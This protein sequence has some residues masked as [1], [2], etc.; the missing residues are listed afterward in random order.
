MCL[1][2]HVRSDGGLRLVD[3]LQSGGTGLVCKM[4]E[5]GSTGPDPPD[6]ASRRCELHRSMWRLQ[7]RQSAM[8]C[9]GKWEA[10]ASSQPQSTLSNCEQIKSRL[11]AVPC[12]IDR[13]DDNLKSVLCMCSDRL[14]TEA[15]RASCL[16][17]E[18]PALA[19]G[20][21]LASGDT[22]ASPERVCSGLA[23]C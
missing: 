9:S 3:A 6:D 22:A 5:A 16:G 20:S 2:R 17:K 10:A 23:L 7:D 4:E 8:V 1:C 19:S 11:I 13:I 18:H 14:Q 15:A 21:L 12:M